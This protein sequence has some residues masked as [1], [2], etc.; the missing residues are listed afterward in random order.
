MTEHPLPPCTELPSWSRL[1]A[2]ADDLRSRFDL[3]RA[4]AADPRRFDRHAVQAPHVRADLSRHWVD[5]HVH[6]ALLSLA[7]DAGVLHRRDAMFRGE[8]VNASEGRAAL[9]WLWR[10]EPMAASAAAP[11]PVVAAPPSSLSPGA[12]GDEGAAAARIT[13]TRA[14]V[15]RERTTMLDWA[16]RVRADPNITDLLHIGIGGSELGPRLVV[17]A[18]GRDRPQRLHFVANVDGHEIDRALRGLEPARTMVLVVSKTFTTIETLLN[19]TVARDWLRAGGGDAAAR[20]VA[21]T[22]APDRAR[23]FGV[24]QCF[25]FD[26]A[27]GGRASLWSPVGAAIAVALGRDGFGRLLAGAAA[28]DRHFREAAPEANLPL[29]LAL[30][31]LWCRDFLGWPSRCVVPYDS[32]LAAWVPYLQQLEM[33][34]NGKGVDAQGRPL[35]AA[36]ASVIWGE[37]GTN[38]QHSFFQ[39]LHQGRDIAPVEFV[40]VREPEHGLAGHHAQLLASVL[41]QAQALM[42]GREDPDPQKACPGNRPSTLLLLDRLDAQSLGALIALHEHRVFCAA[43]IRGSNPFDQWG[44][45]LGKQVAHGLLPR[46]AAATGTAAAPVRIEDG[47][48]QPLAPDPATAG[49]LGWLQR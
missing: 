25:E 44:V 24:G 6:A 4:F 14:L 37:V 9:H 48:A 38:G 8:V 45:E 10:Q 35:P 43:A 1:R 23:A 36:G 17:Q 42:H 41:A 16:E 30:L 28:M 27:V 29:R 3:R 18:L 19:A 12:S 40:V 22:A 13:A 49:V 47:C 33:E 11:G 31:D 46:V 15:V 34:S 32:R 20:M 39:W 7:A 2:L 21:V 5:E 26:E